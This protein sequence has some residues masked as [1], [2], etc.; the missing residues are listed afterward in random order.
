MLLTLTGVVEMVTAPAAPEAFLL[1]LAGVP[2]F[3]IISLVLLEGPGGFDG[4]GW[5]ELLCAF[6]AVMLGSSRLHTGHLVGCPLV[7]LSTLSEIM[8]ISAFLSLLSY[9]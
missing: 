2:I 7:M 4:V 9:L 8:L 6:M 1:A 5:A 3:F